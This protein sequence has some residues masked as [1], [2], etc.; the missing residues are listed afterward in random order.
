MKTIDFIKKELIIVLM[1]VAQ[2]VVLCI[3]WA[4]LPQRV[5]THWD[6]NGNV[7]GYTEKGMGLLIL[8]ALN[9]GI[10]FLLLLLPKID[11]RKANYVQFAPAF[12]IIRLMVHTLLSVVYILT[13]LNSVGYAINITFIMKLLMPVL[14]LVLGNIMGKIRPN[15][16]VG[17]RTPWTLANEQVWVKTHR[18][19]GRVWVAISFI[20][21]FISIF[22]QLPKWSQIVYI[23][24][25]IAMPYV[26][27]YLKYQQIHKAENAGQ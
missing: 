9:I 10:Y 21:L 26:Y 15:Y 18:I 27:S 1:I 6:M 12:K 8:P 24:I 20:Y 11:P 7:N 17:I 25:L 4:Q 5:P 14:F 19:T 3:Y 16:F 13:I 2:I 23:V 22:I